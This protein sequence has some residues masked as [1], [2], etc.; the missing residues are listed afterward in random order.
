MS[1]FLFFSFQAFR[2]GMLEGICWKSAVPG[3]PKATPPVQHPVPV[4]ITVHNIH[5]YG[6]MCICIYVCTCIHVHACRGLCMWSSTTWRGVPRY[7]RC[8]MVLNVCHHGLLHGLGYM[9]CQ[10]IRTVLYEGHRRDVWIGDE[11]DLCYW[12]LWGFA[13]KYSHLTIISELYI[14]VCG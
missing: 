5:V 3:I 9:P 12:V 1:C 13:L 2:V 6:C 4:H 10:S 14:V 7:E 8:A 11:C